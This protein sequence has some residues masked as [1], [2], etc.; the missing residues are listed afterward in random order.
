MKIYQ[1]LVLGTCL[2]AGCKVLEPKPTARINFM[3]EDSYPEGLAYDSLENVYYVSSARLG[4]IGKVTPTGSYNPLYTDNT[5]KSSY[6]MKV[7]P[8]GKRLFVCVGDANYSKF[9][10]P[11]TRK[12]MARLLIIDI[13]SGRKISDI[14]LAGL[15]PGKHFPNDLTFDDN[16]NAY[17]TDSFAHAIYKVDANGKASL[18]ASDPKLVTEGVGVNGIIYHKAGFLLVDNTATGMVYKI[19]LMIQPV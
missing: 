3:A 2:F 13:A 7:H 11:D 14:D 5:V 17:I 4:T 8:D 19:A 9:T 1:Y 16:G 10:S 18:F 15:K 6:G 12:K